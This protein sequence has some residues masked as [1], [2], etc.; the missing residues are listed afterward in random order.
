M[1]FRVT[2]ADGQVDEVRV[3]PS[4]RRAFEAEHNKPLMEAVKS[5]FSDWGDFVVWKTLVL[6]HGL[7]DDLDTWLAQVDRLEMAV[8]PPDPT[9]DESAASPADSSPPR[10]RRKSS[11]P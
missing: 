5:G 11:K 3:I 1:E 7:T 10:T 4:A 8:E 2:Y 6:R 9:G